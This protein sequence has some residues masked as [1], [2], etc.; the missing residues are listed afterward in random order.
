VQIYIKSRGMLHVRRVIPLLRASG[1]VD[2]VSPL[3]IAPLQCIS[4]RSITTLFDH[5]VA[6]L[7]NPVLREKIA[8]TTHAAKQWQDGRMDTGIVTQDSLPDTPSRPA[9]PILME[10]VP[11]HTELGLPLF[12]HILH[13]VAHIELNAC[14]MYW[15]CIYVRYLRQ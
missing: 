12:I 2:P 10:R 4:R 13:S 7:R 11:S 1:V 15:V 5:G 8:I 6:A 9:K 3:R 14:D